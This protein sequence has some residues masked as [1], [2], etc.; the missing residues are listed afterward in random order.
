M[1]WEER[2]VCS[3]IVVN[4]NPTKLST[5]VCTRHR[6][7]GTIIIRGR[8]VNAKRVTRDREMSG[9][10][11]LCN[12]ANFSLKRGF[13]ARTRGLNTRFIRK[14]IARIREIGN[15]FSMGVSNNRD[16]RAGAMV[17]TTKARHEGL[18]MGNR[19][20]FS[21]GKIS[22]YT[23][24]STT[25]CGSG[26]A[27]MANNNSAT[28]NSTLLLSEFYGGICL[29]REESSFETNETLRGEIFTA[30]GVRTLAGTAMSRVGKSAGIASIALLRGKRRGRLSYGNIFITIKDIPSAGPLTGLI[31]ASGSNCVV[32][33]RGKGAS[34]SNVFTN[35]SVEAGTLHRIIATIS[36]NTGYIVSTRGCLSRGRWQR[37]DRV[38]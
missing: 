14:R 21:N 23:I 13:E 10:P 17:C 15:G 32:T 12:R 28:L 29:I 22:C 33:S 4:D 34:T 3:V 36:S 18:N 5:T 27:I 16:L 11:K 38:L 31:G 25:F 35:N 20:R 24:Y 6:G 9:C 37:K 8:F 26:V 19:G 7:L 2:V 1:R 30:R